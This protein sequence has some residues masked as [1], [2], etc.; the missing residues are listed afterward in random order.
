MK[1]FLLI[2]SFDQ[3]LHLPWRRR[4]HWL[5]HDMTCW[6]MTICFLHFHNHIEDIIFT[7]IFIIIRS[8]ICPGGEESTGPCPVAPSDRNILYE[9]RWSDFWL[10]GLCIDNHVDHHDC[11]ANRN[12]L[13]KNRWPVFL[14]Q[15]QEIMFLIIWGLYMIILWIN[16]KYNFNYYWLNISTATFKY[17][18]HNYY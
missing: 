6:I 13:Y 12:I 7:I 14:L 10:W 11:Y 2:I 18:H 1:L 3:I 17:H 4:K 8:Y 5:K 9:N 16:I 15:E